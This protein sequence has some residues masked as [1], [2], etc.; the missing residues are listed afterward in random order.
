MMHGTE[1]GMS[2][3][4]KTH[5]EFNDIQPVSIPFFSLSMVLMHFLQWSCSVATS[6]TTMVILGGSWWKWC[7]ADLSVRSDDVV[8]G[9]VV[10]VCSEHG[11]RPLGTEQ[12]GGS[13][14]TADAL[15]HVRQSDGFPLISQ[16]LQSLTEK[17]ATWRRNHFNFNHLSYSAEDTHIRTHTHSDTNEYTRAWSES[18]GW[19]QWQPEWRTQQ[20]IWHLHCS[21]HAIILKQNRLSG[22][23]YINFEYSQQNQCFLI[24]LDV[25]RY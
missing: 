23:S 19:F 12:R 20:D 9:E 10:S 18:K 16:R 6:E 11:G 14:G 17:A 7:S 15:R 13:Y 1:E 24:S 25:C 3:K 22:Y 4:S 8:V 21:S 2:W 5:L